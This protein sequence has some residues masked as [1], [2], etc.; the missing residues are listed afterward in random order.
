MIDKY[1]QY[2]DIGVV[3]FVSSDTAKYV[4]ISLKPFGGVRVTVPKRSSVRQAMMF[5]EQKKNWILKAQSRMNV[6]EQRYTVFTPETI[7]TMHHHKLQLLPWKSEYFREQLTKDTLTV[8]YPQDIDLSLDHAQVKIREYIDQ[9]IRKEAKMYLP[10]RTDTLAHE[11]GFTYKGL[12]IK[13]VTSRWG[14]CSVTNHIN[15]NMHL[16]RLPH[17]LSDY[18]IL[19][20]LVHTIHKNHSIHF[21]Q[22]LNEHTD[23][24]AKY[25][26]SEM[27]TYHASYY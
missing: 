27:K 23:N 19:H 26:A 21:W 17:S 12:T 16:M 7:F 25:L 11:H 3:Q 2:D 22:C 5:V 15:L 20:E 4:R 13:N 24:K 6:H 9:T 10:Q 14:S 8:F 18:V 1:I